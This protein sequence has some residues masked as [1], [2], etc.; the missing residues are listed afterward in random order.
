MAHE[1]LVIAI[2]LW[3]CVLMGLLYWYLE[4]DA[5]KNKVGRKKNGM[6]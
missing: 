6:A 1:W 3:G 5:K 2:P 4:W